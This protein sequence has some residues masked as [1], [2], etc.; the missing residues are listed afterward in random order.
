MAILGFTHFLLLCDKCRATV[1][2]RYYSCV[3]DPSYKWSGFVTLI[4]NGYWK[5]DSQDTVLSPVPTACHHHQHRIR[6]TLCNREKEPLDKDGWVGETDGMA[7]GWC[8]RTLPANHYICRYNIRIDSVSCV[9]DICCCWMSGEHKFFAISLSS[10]EFPPPHFV[11]A[12]S[13]MNDINEDDVDEG[14]GGNII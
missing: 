14:D 2:S 9:I 3:W 13:S 8:T 12:S 4:A 10:R 7:V 6:I 11:I 5:M 1:I